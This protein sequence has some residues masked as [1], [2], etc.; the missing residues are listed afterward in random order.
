MHTV[1]GGNH[2]LH[3]TGGKDKAEEALQAALAAACTFLGSL[4]SVTLPGLA[5]TPK[6]LEKNRGS[7][8][9]QQNQQSAGKAEASPSQL[10]RSGKRKR[11]RV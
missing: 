6:R 9:G 7:I 3:A 2:S 8:A 11:E 10:M 5:D 4:E 1:I